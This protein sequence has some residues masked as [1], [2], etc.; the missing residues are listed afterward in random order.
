MELLHII[1]SVVASY[2]L[3]SINSA[4]IIS[5]ALYKEDIRTHGSGNAGLTNMLR[6]YGGKAAAL[7]LM[8]DMLKAVIAILFTSIFFGLSYKN[9][10]SLSQYCYLSGL[11]AV[12]GHVFPIFYGFKGGKGV[13]VAATMTLILC[14]IHFLTL[15]LVF[16]IIVV[17]SKYVSL[18]SIVVATLLPISVCLYI[19]LACGVKL[20]MIIAISLI[21]LGGF[22]VWCHRSNIKRLIAGNEKKISIGGKKKKND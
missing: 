17:I 6:T 1:L 20:P 7:T 14:P 21:F 5:R 10:I 3:G 2:L 4:I 16:I 9:G 18:G 11:S 12:L 13:L 8:G 19:P 22:V 15:I